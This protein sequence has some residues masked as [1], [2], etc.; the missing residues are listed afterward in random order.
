MTPETTQMTTMLFRARLAVLLNIRGWQMAYQRSRAMQLS[1]STD[2]D[3]DTVWGRQGD[4][5]G[6]PGVKAQLG[7]SHV[8]AGQRDGGACK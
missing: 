6:A 4:T 8:P 7:S 3:T 5:G 1:V 2:T